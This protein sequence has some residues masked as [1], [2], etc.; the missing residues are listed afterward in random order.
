[1][2]VIRMLQHVPLKAMIAFVLMF[3]CVAWSLL[4]GAFMHSLLFKA[5]LRTLHFVDPFVA[6]EQ[7][8]R[9]AMLTECSQ[10]TG[11]DACG[12]FPSCFVRCF[13]LTFADMVVASVHESY[14]LLM[15]CSTE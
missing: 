11:I 3:T 2:Y 9:C 5:M 10:M 7:M 4:S 15:N 6:Y 1:M 13:E 8:G 14:P 12:F